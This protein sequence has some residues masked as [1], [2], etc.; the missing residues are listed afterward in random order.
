MA[1]ERASVEVNPVTTDVKPYEEDEKSKDARWKMHQLSLIQR[2]QI[3]YYPILAAIGVP[4]N[5]VA[6]VILSR[7]N[8]GLSRCV[9]LYLVMMAVA[10]LMVVVVDVILNQS[11]GY[12]FPFSVL[13]ITPVCCVRFVLLGA[14]T[15]CSVWLT[16]VF[17]FDRFI[18]ICC[19]N[20]RTTYCTER[21]AAAVIVTVFVLSC[22]K[23]IPWYFVYEPGLIFN[24]LPWFCNTKPSVHI[25][26]TW[27]AFQWLD[28]VS[29]PLLPFTLILLLNVLT[30]RHIAAA[31]RVRR[32]LLRESH[33]E[34]LSDPEMGNRRKSIILLFAIS[35]TFI[36]LWMTSVVHFMVLRITNKYYVSSFNSPSYIFRQ[37]GFMLQELSTCTNTCIYAVT[38]NKFRGPAKEQKKT[39]KNSY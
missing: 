35:G 15:N 31:S 22:L 20:M 26:S 7:G 13:E 25:L 39:L 8:C 29:T 23:N 37:A 3:V 11:I 36:L 9:T 21:R 10:D 2:I 38:Q 1:G 16:V 27:L 33:S 34:K 14:V 4:V 32:R 5:V 12:Y 28:R 24:K 19:P 30:V 17:T 6:I 18:V